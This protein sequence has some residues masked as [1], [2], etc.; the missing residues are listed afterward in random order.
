[1]PA[2]DG[3]EGVADQVR[4]GREETNELRKELRGIANDFGDL[5]RSEVELAKAELREQAAAGAQ[6]ASWAAVAAVA[7]VLTFAFVFVTEL[8]LLNEVVPAWVA[9]LLT[10]GTIAAVTGLAMSIASARFRQVRFVPAKTISSVREDV[11][12]A[13]G[14]VRSSSRSSESVTP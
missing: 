6:A 3:L 9:A 12:W 10:T 1:M 13:K 8:F 2:G 4:R 14:Q 11:R 7:A 5:M